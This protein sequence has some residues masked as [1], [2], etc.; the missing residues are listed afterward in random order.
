[1]PWGFFVVYINVLKTFV[2]HTQCMH[3]ALYTYSI[4]NS[5]RNECKMHENKKDA[6]ELGTT[7]LVNLSSRIS[8]NACN[9]LEEIKGWLT[10]EKDYGKASKQE[11]LEKAILFYHAYILQALENR[12]RE[13][14]EDS[15]QVVNI[16]K[17]QDEKSIQVESEEEQKERE[18]QALLKRYAPFEA[19]KNYTSEETFNLLDYK[20]HTR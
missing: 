18:R 4:G 19:T 2:E 10:T 8:Q 7:H 9:K 12:D 11:A 1:M 6:I 5:E 13:L 16:Q 17:K 3:F 14:H 15:K 20:K